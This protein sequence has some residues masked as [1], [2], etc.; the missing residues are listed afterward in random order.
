MAKLKL[1]LDALCVESFETAEETER[2]GTVRGR[3]YTSGPM[4]CQYQCETGNP[5][6]Y[7]CPSEVCSGDA[8]QSLSGC[9]SNENTCICTNDFC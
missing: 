9:Q 7:G 2:R 1:E 8:C 6:N 5:S 4:E 3:E